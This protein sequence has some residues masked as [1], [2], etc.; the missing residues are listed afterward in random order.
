[1]TLQF[2]LGSLH[3]PLNPA[4]TDILNQFV[5][6]WIPGGSEGKESACNAGDPGSV[7]GLGRS[8]VEGS[9]N[10]FNIEGA[11]Y[12]V[13][14]WGIPWTEESGGLQSMKSQKSGA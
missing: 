2:T 6:L 5:Y 4:A 11:T 1:M 10:L 13:C 3:L 8:P 7:P 9:G 14:P 12:S